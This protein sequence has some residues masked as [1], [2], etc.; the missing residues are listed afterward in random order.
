MGPSG[1][2]TVTVLGGLETGSWRDPGVPCSM[3]RWGWAVSPNTQL[4]VSFSEHVPA[5][6]GD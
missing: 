6:P 2:P 5:G 3:E 1:Q 4:A